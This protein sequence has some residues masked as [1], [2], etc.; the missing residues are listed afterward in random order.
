MKTMRKS[1]VSPEQWAARMAYER[2]WKARNRERHRQKQLESQRRRMA[3]PVK[4]AHQNALQRRYTRE[5][6]PYKHPRVG[7]SFTQDLVRELLELQQAC[8]AVCGQPF[9]SAKKGGGY[10]RDHDHHSGKARGLLCFRCN[11]IEGLIRRLGI[12]HT[13]YLRRLA[14]YLLNPPALRRSAT[15]S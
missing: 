3:D 9:D 12:E 2:E 10:H 1:D 11:V 5:K 4:R 7:K 14:D 13:E 15:R 6:R 8:C